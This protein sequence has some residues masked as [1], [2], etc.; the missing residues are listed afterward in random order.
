MRI[1]DIDFPEPL[2]ASQRRRDLV[3]FAG[4]GVSIPPPSNY[5]DF[6]ELAA[7]VGNGVL[8]R[9]DGEP[10]DRFLGRLYDKGV[11]VHNLVATILTDPLSRPNPLHSDLL[12]LFPSAATVRLVTTNFDRHFTKTAL[13]LFEGNGIC[14]FYEAPALPLGDSFNG[15][16]YLH[17]SVDKTPERLVLTDR[18]FGRAISLCLGSYSANGLNWWRFSPRRIRRFPFAERIELPKK[19]ILGLVASP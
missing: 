16:I 3:I 17:G 14:E 5:P 9:Q 8:T 7:K 2:L 6:K 10:I 15:I 11:K 12:K 13:D 1:R 19:L 4:A 18:D